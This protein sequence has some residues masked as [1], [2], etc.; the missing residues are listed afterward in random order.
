MF[1]FIGVSRI[2][3]RLMGLEIPDYFLPSGAFN[4]TYNITH[5]IFGSKLVQLFSATNFFTLGSNFFWKLS[6]LS[7]WWNSVCSFRFMTV[8]Y[9]DS[10]KTFATSGLDTCHRPNFL[11]FPFNPNNP[12][13]SE[14]K[15]KF[16]KMESFIYPFT[17]ILPR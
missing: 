2:T 13:S 15:Y 5:Y 10:C 6:N 1:F 11:S 16:R 3:V 4:W 12:P 8:T 14:K 9:S 7:W 17:K